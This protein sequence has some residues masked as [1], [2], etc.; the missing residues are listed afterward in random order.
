MPAWRIVY[1]MSHISVCLCVVCE[2]NGNGYCNDDHMRHRDRGTPASEHYWSN[3]C[4]RLSSPNCSLRRGLDTSFGVR[5][6][7]G[8]CAGPVLSSKDQS[9][10]GRDPEIATEWSS[11]DG[12]FD[13]N[14]YITDVLLKCTNNKSS[15]ECL[16]LSFRV[17]RCLWR[18]LD[19]GLGTMYL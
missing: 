4:L 10:L 17:C 1:S 15:E 12:N 6:N 16:V 5:R 13:Y 9:T 14:M 8:Q 18:V 2:C 11:C 19:E 3:K 7:N